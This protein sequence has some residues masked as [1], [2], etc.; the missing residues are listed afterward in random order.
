MKNLIQLV[1]FYQIINKQIR[2]M[3]RKDLQ[4]KMLQKKKKKKLQ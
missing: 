4:C 2:D 3:L 1:V